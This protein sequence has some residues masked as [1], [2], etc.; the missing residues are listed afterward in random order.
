[1]ILKRLLIPFVILA[2]TAEA[3][4]QRG[5]DLILAEIEANPPPTV[6]GQMRSKQ[7]HDRFTETIRANQRVRAALALELWRAAPDHDLLLE[8]LPS[9]WGAMIFAMDAAQ[10]VG[11]EVA[12]ALEG[13]LAELLEPQAFYF[14]ALA[15]VHAHGLNAATG[16]E[17]RIL[18]GDYALQEKRYLRIFEACVA[19]GTREDRLQLLDVI[20]ELDSTPRTLAKTAAWKRQLDGIGKPL[21]LA[22]VDALSGRQVSIE[23]YRGKVVILD[24]WATW[25]LPCI[26]EMPRLQE[27]R[28]AHE[29]VEV[30]GV[31]LDLPKAQGGLR[32]VRD[33]AKEHG[34][35]WPQYHQGKGWDS[36]FS[37]S[38]GVTALPALFL[39]DRQGNLASTTARENLEAEIA[40]LLEDT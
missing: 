36:E 2:S 25:C 4:E 18:A 24:F 8:M 15:H 13:P 10:T 5:V 16:L 28:A 19:E 35:D 31:S 26:A 11:L 40:R 20:A 21:E 1:M 32:L 14:R 3:Q 12:E 17:A 27:L 6:N 9:R 38:W 39:V 30:I 29:D 33:F 22:F 23:D 37:S 34:Y 7:D